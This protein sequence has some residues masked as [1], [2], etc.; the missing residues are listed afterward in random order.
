MKDLLRKRKNSIFYK[1]TNWADS[2]YLEEIGVYIHEETTLNF[3]INEMLEVDDDEF[4]NE[5]NASYFLNLLFFILNH[6]SEN[7]KCIVV[8]EIYF[9]SVTSFAHAYFKLIDEESSS[10]DKK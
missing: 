8:E 7:K 6:Y 9:Q 4:N 10:Q 3:T 2:T 1:L 5:F